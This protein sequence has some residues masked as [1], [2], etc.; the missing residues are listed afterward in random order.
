MIIRRMDHHT[1]SSTLDAGVAGI[2]VAADVTPRWEWRTF[3]RGTL[4][5]RHDLLTWVGAPEAP[6]D[7]TYLLSACSEDN[8]KVRNLHLEIKRLERRNS[9]LE[10]W[11]P[12]L[13]AAFPVG[14]RVLDRVYAAWRVREPVP[15]QTRYTLAE[16]EHEIVSPAAALR[17]VLVTKRRTRIESRECH[18][19]LVELL[20]QGERWESVAF[21]DPDPARV[22]NA[23]RH[24][25]LARF[26][27][28]SYPAALKRIAGLAA[29]LP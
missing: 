9:G 12:V 24:L 17:A 1:G 20:V 22:L 4:P 15:R 27:N 28:T 23:V 25:A 14:M 19:E 13:R 26:A 18:G 11:I 8:V 2:V 29:A 16:L 6:R 5:L 21:E 3:V 10:L 7:E